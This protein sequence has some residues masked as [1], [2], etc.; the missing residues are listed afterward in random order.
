MPEVIA[1][2]EYLYDLIK[3]YDLSYPVVFDME[4]ADESDRIN[5]LSRGQKT[6]LAAAFV[7]AMRRHGFQV[8]IYGSQN[9]LQQDI[10]MAVLQDEA[11]FWLAAYDVEFPRFAYAYSCWQYSHTGTIDGISTLVDLDVMFVRK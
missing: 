6:M 8:T 7:Q 2:A 3:D 10:S 9:W 5:T 1:E 4:Q 11:D